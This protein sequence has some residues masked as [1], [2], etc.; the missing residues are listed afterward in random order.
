MSCTVS[1]YNRN[2]VIVFHYWDANTFF[3][4]ISKQKYRYSKV[5]LRYTITI[6][7]YHL[8]LHPSSLFLFKLSIHCMQASAL[9]AADNNEV[10]KKMCAKLVLG[11]ASFELAKL[12]KMYNIVIINNEIKMS[13]SGR[14]GRSWRNS[15]K[16]LKLVGY[17]PFCE[18]IPGHVAVVAPGLKLMR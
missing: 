2:I 9:F 14:S 16:R 11:T 18:R 4:C 3:L 8:A 1:W 10:L 12:P 15:K 13:S 6:L 7:L 17:V 5:S